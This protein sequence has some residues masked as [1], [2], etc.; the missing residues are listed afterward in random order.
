M[1]NAIL[2]KGNRIIIANDLHG[3]IRNLIHSGHQDIDKCI[4]RA[5]EHVFRPS[6]TTENKDLVNN[7]STSF[8]ECNQLPAESAISHEISEIPWNKITT[9]I[10]ELHKNA[11]VIAVD[12]TNKFLG[13]HSL[14]EKQS[15]TVIMHLTSLLAKFGIPQS[16]ISDNGP[17]FKEIMFTMLAKDWDFQHNTSNNL[18]ELTT[19][20]VKRTLKKSMKSNQDSYSTILSPR[21]TTPFMGRNLRTTQSHSEHHH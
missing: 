21:T 2:I 9:D 14:T 1:L 11:Y 6:I 18:V 13:I 4:V 8:N 10:F 15:F 7:C 17:E 19:Q 3:E 5:R 16:V 12:Y 20:I